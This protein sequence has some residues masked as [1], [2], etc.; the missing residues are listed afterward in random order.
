MHFLGGG[1]YGGGLKSA[2]NSG[3]VAITVRIFLRL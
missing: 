2:V 1:V 3:S